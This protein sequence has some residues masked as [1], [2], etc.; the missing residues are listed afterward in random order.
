LLVYFNSAAGSNLVFNV[1][2][3]LVGKVGHAIIVV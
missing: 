2:G 1:I 3:L